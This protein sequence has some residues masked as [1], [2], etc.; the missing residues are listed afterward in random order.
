MGPIEYVEFAFDE[1]EICEN[2][3]LVVF[4]YS[5]SVEDSIKLFR[6]TKLYG[7]PIIT[8]NYSKHL[9]DP[10]FNDQ[11]NY[12]KQLVN[13]ERDQS[14]D[15]NDKS[16]WNDHNTDN[17]FNIPD[18]LPEP[19][20][21]DC[22]NINKDNY[23]HKSDIISKHSHKNKSSR[24][25]YDNLNNKN[26]LIEKTHHSHEF[27]R[28]PGH[29]TS[30]TSSS[31]EMS[32]NHKDSY[33]NK[34]YDYKYRDYNGQ[35]SPNWTKNT[36]QNQEFSYINKKN[37]LKDVHDLRNALYQKRSLSDSDYHY[38]TNSNAGYTSSLDLRESLH[39]NKRS[40]YDDVEHY[41]ESNTNSQWLE[42]NKKNTHN[43]SNFS[44]KISN[45]NNYN[46]E[47]FSESGNR[48]QNHYTDRDYN[49]QSFIQDRSSYE[50]YQ[51]HDN[52]HLNNYNDGHSQEKNRSNNKYNHMHQDF[53]RPY[54]QNDGHQKRSGH[55]RGK[56]CNKGNT[57][58][59]RN[60][61]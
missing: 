15:N 52:T 32:N 4:K 31:I 29:N 5:S 53:C 40:K 16:R 38:D 42:I 61:Y 51:K 12:F 43:N 24:Y 10:V 27:I 13:V 55:N 41:Y 49:N 19:P 22:K 33:N 9:E 44:N 18:S 39:H 11:L 36:Y 30:F 28:K 6:G 34:N 3:A 23:D 21:Y 17:K 1:H 45:K 14:N 46:S 48:Y 2:F 59:S 54:K 25:E 57:E 50:S 8:K 60:N 7:L 20:V 47:H 58:R 35:T 56:N 37:C 26:L